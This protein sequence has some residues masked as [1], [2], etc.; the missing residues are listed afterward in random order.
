MSLKY[1]N[2]IKV[3]FRF[4]MYYHWLLH[5]SMYAYIYLFLVFMHIIIDITIHLLFRLLL[6]I[7]YCLLIILP[8]YFPN[9]KR[10]T[11]LKEPVSRTS[12]ERVRERERENKT[13]P[14]LINDLW[15]RERQLFSCALS[16]PGK[17]SRQ[18]RMFP[19]PCRQGGQHRSQPVPC[20]PQVTSLLGSNAA[21]PC[22]TRHQ[23]LFSV[24]ATG[25]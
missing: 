4:L 6:L 14:S 3:Y 22:S 25:C 1:H 11:T 10:N 19:A 24:F 7:L 12:R 17:V 2:T 18:D 20:P 9:L 16:P 21:F 23:R 5:L 13:P 15:H 8:D